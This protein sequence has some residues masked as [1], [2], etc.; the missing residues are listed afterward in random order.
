MSEDIPPPPYTDDDEKN[1]AER[2]SEVESSERS[3]E[4]EQKIFRFLEK[5]QNVILSGPGGTGKSFMLKSIADK[6]VANCIR[7]AK[8]GS[9]GISADNIGGMTIHSWAGIELGDKSVFFYVSKIKEFPKYFLRWVNTTVLIIDEISMIGA[10]VF[11]KLSQIGSVLRDDP[12]PF[13]G[14]TLLLC[15]DICQLPPVKDQYFFESS[16]Y[17]QMKFK[18]CRLT[19]PWRFQ[20][21]LD[22]FQLLSRVRIGKQTEEDIFK[23]RERVSIYNKDIRKGERLQGG[24]LQG[25]QGDLGIKP[26]RMFSKKMDVSAMNMKELSLLNEEEFEYVCYDSVSK[27]TDE[28]DVSSK[29]L[30]VFQAQMEKNV[31]SSIKLKK[32]AQVMLTWNLSPETGFCNGSRGVVIECFEANVKVLFK[33]GEQV[34]IEP[35][36]WKIETDNEIFTRTQMPLI[37]AWSITIHKSQGSTL[38]CV[39]IDLGTSIFSDNMAYVALS[40]CRSIDG[41]YIVN[42]IPEKIRCNPKA[43][44]F[45]NIL[46]EN[47][48]G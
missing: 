1:Y 10:T 28:G 8:T 41:L 33:N 7:V 31:P 3:S 4:T 22:F 36:T 21:D 24:R 9:T 40:R 13:G 43:L 11:D 5:R 34:N 12:R 20:N 26:T 27:K 32:G 42:I 35:K 47:D 18:I 6:L 46:I 44:E 48:E 14:M 39:I 23:L 37:L 38:D 17:K 25:G 45:E 16:A 15:G 2:V 29:K 19:H 30:E